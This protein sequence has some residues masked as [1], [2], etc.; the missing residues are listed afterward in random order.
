MEQPR[1]IGRCPV[2]GDEMQ[3]T[4]LYCSSCRTSIEGRFDTC[5]FCHLNQEQMNFLEIFIRSR[6]NIKEVE[7]EMGISYPTV[8]NRL[9]NVLRALGYR[10][11]ADSQQDMVSQQEARKRR[12]EILNRL[13]DGEI[14]PDEAARLIREG[15]ADEQ[16]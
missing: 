1:M 9:D 11:E 15:D 2:C 4:R 6:G 3:V 16:E 12:I 7:R 13:S 5:K 8:R 10:V 14:D